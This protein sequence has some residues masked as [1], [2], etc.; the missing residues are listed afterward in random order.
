MKYFQDYKQLQA[1]IY[2]LLKSPATKECETTQLQ[3][4]IFLEIRKRTVTG[5]M[6][7][8]SMYSCKLQGNKA[9]L[10]HRTYEELLL[11]LEQSL[12]AFDFSE[13]LFIAKVYR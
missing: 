4:C 11:T 8:S 7:R 12:N 9:K 2:Y 3:I 13:T 10:Q 6:A 1:Q 5:T